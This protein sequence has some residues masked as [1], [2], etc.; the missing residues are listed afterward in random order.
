MSEQG[1]RTGEQTKAEAQRVALSFFITKG[2]EATSLREIAEELGISKAALYYHFKSKEDIV[3]EG[4]LSRG[5]EAADLLAWA[6]TQEPGPDLV[7]AAVL[8]W[9]GSASVDKLRGVRFMNANPALLRAM[10]DSFGIGNS[11]EQLVEVVAGD[12]PAPERLLLIRMAFLSINSAV[13]AS[14]G[15]QLRDDEIVA[16]ARENAVALL[17]R[18]RELSPADR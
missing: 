17:A 13:M 12:D 18:I 10:N 6:R 1:R 8:R 14:E 5:T 4:M 9:V 3:K 16:V 2:Y 7:E 11:L 15:T